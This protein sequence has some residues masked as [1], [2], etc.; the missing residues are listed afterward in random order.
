M[1]RT[2]LAGR[3]ATMLLLVVVAAGLLPSPSRAEESQDGNPFIYGIASHAWWLDP[4]VYG[5][6][7]CAA[8][9]DLNVTTV[10]LS[11][12]W[13]RFEPV[14]GQFDWRLYDAV[15]GELA[16]RDIVIVADF[17]TIPGW[18]S[19]DRR[20]L[21]IAGRAISTMIFASGFND[22]LRLYNR[23]QQDRIDFNLAYI[24]ADFTTELKEPFDQGY[25]RALFDYGYRQGRAGYRWAKAPP[26]ARL[27]Q[28]A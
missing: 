1:T 20:T 24:G 23:T 5:D 9:D 10:R 26:L 8:L 14:Q 16:K 17:N 7:L 13:R 25:M 15:F 6:Q 19:V 12:D 18:A 28:T 2:T 21:G 3:I 22:V 27:Q 4:E 11:I